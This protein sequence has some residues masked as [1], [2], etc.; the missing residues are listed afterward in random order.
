MKLESG[1]KYLLSEIKENP[2]KWNANYFGQ[3]RGLHFLFRFNENPKEYSKRKSNFDKRLKALDQTDKK[4][5]PTTFSVKVLLY[6][7][8]CIIKSKTWRILECSMGL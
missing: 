8:W 7:Q 6:L 1:K 2:T 3:L 4:I 5:P